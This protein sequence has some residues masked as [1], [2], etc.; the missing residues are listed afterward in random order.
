MSE[1]FSQGGYGF[2]IW[3]AYGISALALGGL[4]LWVISS[5]RAAKARLAEFEERKAP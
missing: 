2:Y 1:F 5:Y 4:T 3:S